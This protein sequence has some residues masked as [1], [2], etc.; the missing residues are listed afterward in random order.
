MNT[1]NPTPSVI[2]G[3]TRLFFIIGDPISQVGSPQLFNSLFQQHQIAAAMLPC[4]VLP[5]D[6]NVVIKGLRRQQNL[7]GIIVTVPHKV[8]VLRL[9][10]SLTP[11]ARATGAVNAIRRNTD[12]SL[13]GANFDGQACVRTFQQL[14]ADLRNQSVLIIGAGGAGRAV[15]HACLREGASYLRLVE[16]RRSRAIRLVRG[17]KARFP[18]AII[19][20]GDHNPGGFTRVVNCSPSGMTTADAMPIDIDHL[21]PG[22][23]VVDLILRPV[24]PP[25]LKAA[26][27][28]GCQ[29]AHGNTVLAAQV[30]LIADFF[31]IARG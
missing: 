1:H 9:I 17:L 14:G 28:M 29:T 22:T 26:K 7:G 11:E 20:V 8:R 24:N 30:D 5:A 10:D 21:D 25:L 16:K 3:D 2:N 23:A 19:D 13:Y 6:L 15:A 31:L 18:H 12:G 4:H 27:E